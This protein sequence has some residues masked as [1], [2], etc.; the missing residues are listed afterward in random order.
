MAHSHI[1]FGSLM[2]LDLDRT[3]V[4]C[5]IIGMARV[6]SCLIEMCSSTYR[7]QACDLQQYLMFL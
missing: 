2:Y 6:V 5:R 3:D 7:E 4:S 1:A